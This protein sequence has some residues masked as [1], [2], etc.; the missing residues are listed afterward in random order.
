MGCGCSRKEYDAVDQPS[1]VH[2]DCKPI[3]DDNQKLHDHKDDV[4]NPGQE[5]GN[6]I[7]QAPAAEKGSENNANDQAPI[8]DVNEDLEAINNNNI[9]SSVVLIDTSKKY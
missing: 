8:H 2:G 9:V 4:Q 5:G 7:Q 1:V 6:D 3:Q